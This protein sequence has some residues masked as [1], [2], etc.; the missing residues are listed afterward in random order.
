MGTRDTGLETWDIIGVPN[1]PGRRKFSVTQP[2]FGATRGPSRSSRS[3]RRRDRRT[4]GHQCR[5]R[6]VTLLVREVAIDRPGEHERPHR[7]HRRRARP[8]AR[9][10]A[11]YVATASGGLWKSSE[12]RRVVVARVRRRRRD[13][14][15]RRGRCRAVR[16]ARRCGSAPAKPTRGRARAGATASTRATDGGKTWA[17]M[18]LKDTRS[19]ARIVVDP[20]NAERR[21]R[22]R[23]GTSLGAERRAWRVQDDG[24][25][26]D[27]DE[28]AVRRREH[29]RDRSRHRSGQSAE[30]CTRRRTSASAR[31]G[32]ST[33]AVR[34]PTSTRSI[35]G[36]A[37]WTKL[38]DRS[39]GRR[40]GT[41]RALALR[42]RSEG[43]LRDDR[44]AERRGR[45]LSHARRRHDVGKNVG[46]QHS[47]Q[48][49]LADPRRP[50]GS[51]ARLHAWLE[52]RILLL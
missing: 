37:T 18:G 38:T 47:A 42:D 6:P 50:A 51:R 32:A 30:C 46:A 8:R 25:R 45:H 24:R 12:Q 23:A 29:R 10:D 19:V 3:P 9:P 22:R 16:T 33:A 17:N 2:V 39:A 31:R 43:R 40:Q 1:R 36:G 48:L 49:L 20:T 41:H 34:A 52:S 35:D 7:R 11:I 21:L 14:V 26:Q 27:V 15:D 44:S 28:G 4:L 13:D 5:R